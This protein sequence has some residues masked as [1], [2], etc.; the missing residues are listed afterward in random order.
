MIRTM[1]EPNHLPPSDLGGRRVLCLM[2]ARAEYGAAL[3][4][5][6]E[7]LFI[8]VGP[9]EAAIGTTRALA[10]AEAAG[11]L[12]DLVLSLGSAGSRSL[13]QARVYQVT[14][15]SWR[16]MDASPLGFERGRTPF[17]DL[18]AEIALPFRAPGLPEARLSTGANVV[19]GAGYDAVDA[20][21]VDM[22][23]FAVLR[24]CSGFGVP[25]IGLRG[26]SDGAEELRRYADWSDCL[27]IVDARLGDAVDVLAAT[28]AAGSLTP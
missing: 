6:I 4:A 8:G 3:A 14:S 18:P 19:T 24:A 21:M 2:A 22:E 10:R 25:L 23:T 28:L 1:S 15:V 5:R 12:P 16:D 27:P 20:D 17:L 7:P 13:A 11:A 9:I 26:V